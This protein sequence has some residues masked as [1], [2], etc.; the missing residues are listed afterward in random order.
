MWDN[1]M[2][3]TQLRTK[4]HSNLRMKQGTYFFLN[5]R[6]LVPV[7]MSETPM[8]ALDLP[9]VFTRNKENNLAL[10]ALLSLEKDNNVHV[11][12][13]GLWMGGY[14]PVAVRAH[15][16]SLT[17]YKDQAVVMVN[18]DSD[19]LTTAKD[20]GR[21][22]F[23]AHG[24]PTEWLTKIMD[25]LKNQAPNPHRDNPVL[26]AI[27]AADILEPWPPVP[28]VLCVSPQKLGSLDDTAFLALRQAGALG[29][30]YAHLISLPRI[31]R[32]KHLAQRKQKITEQLRKNT[33]DMALEDDSGFD[34][35][36]MI[37]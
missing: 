30:I 20:Q 17:Y 34:L 23:D 21:L 4:Q 8:A 29:V 25:L 19:W 13:K 28:E 7:S 11:G 10:M 9:L 15:P 12:P 18:E 36:T 27:D 2:T 16:F 26:A 35:G 37:G 1:N 5:D 6:P 24:K 31:Q 33:G 14:K 3:N 22:L 32:I